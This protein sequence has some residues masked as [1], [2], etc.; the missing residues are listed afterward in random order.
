MDSDDMSLNNCS[1][2]SKMIVFY[3]LLGNYHTVWLLTTATDID[4]LCQ[5]CWVN[6]LSGKTVFLSYSLSYV[7]SYSLLLRRWEL[8]M[9]GSQH[10]KIANIELLYLV[11]LIFTWFLD[12]N[13]SWGVLWCV[14]YLSIFIVFLYPS[15]KMLVGMLSYSD[16]LCLCPD[17]TCFFPSCKLLH[18]SCN[19]C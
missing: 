2:L 7:L 10:T 14:L 8:E 12:I 17:P 19:I 18:F 4:R 11:C 9:P 6:L 3:T 1:A 16:N 5:I 15:Y 13:E